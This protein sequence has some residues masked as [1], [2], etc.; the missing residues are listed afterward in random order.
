M[1]LLTSGEYYVVK[2]YNREALGRLDMQIKALKL[3]GWEVIVMGDFNSHVGQVISGNSDKTDSIG[4]E[5]IS[6]AN[7]NSLTIVN[8]LSCCQGLWM[9]VR[10][11]V[12]PVIDYIMIDNVLKNNVSRVVVDNEGGQDL[13]SDHNPMWVRLVNMRIEGKITRTTWAK[14]WNI[15]D[16][17]YWVGFRTEIEERLDSSQWDSTDQALDKTE[18]LIKAQKLTEILTETGRKTI[19]ENERKQGRFTYSE[20]SSK[21]N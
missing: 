12:K 2:R 8:T 7:N 17:T 13:G 11:Q 10:G 9:F 4:K 19:G 21:K 5:I 1:Y 20:Q 15:T 3:K 16:T 18:I 14:K 6:I